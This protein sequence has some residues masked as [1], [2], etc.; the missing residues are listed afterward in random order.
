MLGYES[1]RGRLYTKHQNLFKYASDHEDKEWLAKNHLMSPNGGK[2]FL[3]VLQ[4]IHEL[5]VS[6]EY[7]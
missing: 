1:S 3:C 4:D 5:A 7:K 6:G 2:A